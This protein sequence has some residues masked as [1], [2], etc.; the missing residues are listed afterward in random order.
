M[1]PLLSLLLKEKIE[2]EMKALHSA[3][4]NYKYALGYYTLVEGVF[5]SASVEE[6]IDKYKEAE[7]Y[8]APLGLVF[9][10]PHTAWNPSVHTKMM[11]LH[12][13]FNLAGK[14]HNPLP[15]GTIPVLEQLRASVKKDHDEA[16]A[17]YETLQALVNSLQQQH[18]ALNAEALR[19]EEARHKEAARCALQKQI[20]ALQAQLAVL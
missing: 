16:K 8:F 4:H 12:V 15:D 7:L 2:K 5:A 6:A 18:A 14:P 11:I 19:E 10:T 3:K 9:P 17:R 1:T 13:S 20:A